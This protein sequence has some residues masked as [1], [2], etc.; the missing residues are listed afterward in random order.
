[1][2][3]KM[4]LVVPGLQDQMAGAWQLAYVL[5][6]DSEGANEAA[7]QAFVDVAGDPP[8]D[9]HFR[10]PL[11]AAVVRI[12]GAEGEPT[13]PEDEEARL[14]EVVAN[15]W[16]LSG[17]QRAALWLTQEGMEVEELATVLAISTGE[18]GILV[19]EALDWLEASIDQV[20]G[21]LCPSEPSVPDYLEGALPPD[22]AMEMDEHVPTCPT[23]RARIEAIEGLAELG[24][25]VDNAVPTPPAGLALRAFDRWEEELAESAAVAE[26]RRFADWRSTRPLAACCG[27]LL[28]LGIIGLGVVK[29]VASA[30]SKGSAPVVSS[31]TTTVAPATVPQTIVIPTTTSTTLA[32]PVV[33]PTGH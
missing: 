15:F 5:T 9:G 11:L 1:M 26:S 16:H 19:D 6:N 13:E 27:G 31:V 12:T 25:V 29:P 20:S 18:A 22:Q 24:P 28:L 2:G 7:L 10:I 21:P 14:P 32:P 8:A 3:N 33:F 23:C 17:K 30:T 4:D